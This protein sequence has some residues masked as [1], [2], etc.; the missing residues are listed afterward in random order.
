MAKSKP[1]ADG[2][3]EEQR[4]KRVRLYAKTYFA[5]HR[6]AINARKRAAYLKNREEILEKARLSRLRDVDAA[7]AKD[8]EKRSKYREKRNARNREYMRLAR[9][10][11]PEKFRLRA[12]ESARKNREAARKRSARYYERHKEKALAANN[13]CA[14]KRL[15]N[16][17][18]FA[19]SQRLR[20]RFYRA[21][22]AKSVSKAGKTL[23]LVGC[24][25]AE[26]M[27]HLESQ[28]LP[29]MTWENRSQWHIDHIV[30]L[31]LFDLKDIGQQ[32]AAFHYTNLR[33]LWAIDNHKKGA[34]P[35]LPQHLFGFAYAAKIADAASAK[36]K[37]RRKDGGQHGGH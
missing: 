9:I 5:K 16:D 4:K 36:P 23:D 25:I 13:K 37:K 31:A 19:I 2:K 18:L 35:P 24:S 15:R 30:P 27:A 26:L 8:R 34:K 29:G 11:N 14:K 12:K 10:A 32:L 6:D 17:P 33:P 28:F 1:H 3:Q 21:I 7:K 20:R 22:T